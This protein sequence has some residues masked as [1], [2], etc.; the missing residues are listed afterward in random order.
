MKRKIFTYTI[1]TIL[2]FCEI[3]IA[4]LYK[5][6]L[7]PS[8]ATFHL[9]KE[10]SRPFLS[11]LINIILFAAITVFSMKKNKDMIHWKIVIGSFVVLSIVLLMIGFSTECPVCGAGI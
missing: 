1:L 2:A 7:A 6:Y 3:I 9:E 4:V 11:L 8:W 10:I 5:L